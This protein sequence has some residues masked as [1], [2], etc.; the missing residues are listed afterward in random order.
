MVESVLNQWRKKAPT[1][2]LMPPNMLF[3]KSALLLAG[4]FCSSL[5]Q[6]RHIN[7]SFVAGFGRKLQLCSHKYNSLF[8]IESSYGNT[9]Q[10]C[11]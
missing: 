10:N 9:L 11:P 7:F 4:N 1:E 5:K 2:K 6:I 3:V 8:D